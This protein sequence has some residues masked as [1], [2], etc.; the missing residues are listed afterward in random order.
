MLGVKKGSLFVMDLAN[1]KAETGEVAEED[2]R[3]TS[4]AALVPQHN[5]T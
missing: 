5:D 4:T 1:V 2:M 3:K